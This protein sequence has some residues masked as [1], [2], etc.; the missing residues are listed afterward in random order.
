MLTSTT[1]TTTIANTCSSS[2]GSRTGKPRPRP[3]R[4]PTS[5]HVDA[6]SPPCHHATCRIEGQQGSR[7]ALAGRQGL[8]MSNSREVGDITPERG[9]WRA[10]TTRK[11]PNDASRVVWALGVFFFIPSFFFFILTNVLAPPTLA[12]LDAGQKDPQRVP[13]TR[14]GVSSSILPRR[15]PEQP[16][17]SQ[18]DSLGGFFLSPTSTLA[19][20]TPNES[21]GLVRGVPSSLLSRRRPERPPASPLTRWGVPFSLPPQRWPERPPTSPEIGRAHV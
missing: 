6:T 3:R 8:K 7:W 1:T 10:A 12:Y 20:T 15:R 2:S 11:G 16:P 9:R 19:R 21:M 14:W 17:T 5:S 13:L 4:Q 18:W